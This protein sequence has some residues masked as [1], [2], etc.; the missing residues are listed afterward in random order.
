MLPNLLNHVGVSSFERLSDIRREMDKLFEG[1]N[2]TRT[3]QPALDAEETADSLI[4]HLEVPGISADQLDIHV[5]GNVL[6]ISGENKYQHSSQE[7]EKRYRYVERQYGR[8]QRRITLPRTVETDKVQADYQNGVLT[9]V[10]PKAEKAK[11]R[12]I[13][14]G[15]PAQAQQ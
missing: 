8:F 4:F 6:T 11:P 10:L 7:H 9:L 1:T 15:T 3:W 13:T 12:K 5:D 2:G 14:I